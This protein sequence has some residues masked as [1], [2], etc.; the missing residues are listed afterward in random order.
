MGIGIAHQD[1]KIEFDPQGPFGRIKELT[2][3]YLW[4]GRGERV[5]VHTLNSKI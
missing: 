2:P 5:C 4:G 3:A 1:W